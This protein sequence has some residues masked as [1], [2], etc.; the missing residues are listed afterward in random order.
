MITVS[1]TAG[2]EGIGI[3]GTAAGE[4]EAKSR[5]LKAAILLFAKKGHEGVGIQEI[6]GAAGQNSSLISYHF[7]GKEGIHQA[8][9]SL[10]CRQVES[11]VDSFPALPGEEEPDTRPRAEAALRETIRTFLHFTLPAPPP[12]DGEGAF[13]LALIK[14][15]LR[16][17]A[18]PVPETETLVLAAARPH[19]NYMNHCIQAISPD[20]DARSALAIGMGIYGQLLFFLTYKGVVP[21]FGKAGFAEASLA[22]LA[23]HLTDF[24]LRGLGPSQSAFPPEE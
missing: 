20:L 2:I 22:S 5:L 17:L 23:D 13:T 4:G 10:A 24:V 1:N 12:A 15:F 21:S 11:L 18:A 8:A 3:P 9:V 14:L 7:G 6:A 19:A 16:E